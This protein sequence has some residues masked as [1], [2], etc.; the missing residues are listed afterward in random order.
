MAIL[1]ASGA[2]ASLLITQDEH[3]PSTSSTQAEQPVPF[4]EYEFPEMVIQ[5][6]HGFKSDGGL[7]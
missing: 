3:A 7:D 6:S 1:L 4:E 2:F 5:P